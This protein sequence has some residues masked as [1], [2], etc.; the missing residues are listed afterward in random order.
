[1]KT[2]KVLV[3][4]KGSQNGYSEAVSFIRGGISQISDYLAEVAL[5]EGFIAEISEAGKET[6]EIAK[7][8]PENKREKKIRKPK[9]F[10]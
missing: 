2:Y 5:K 3:D 9:E 4:F 6:P 1:M 8:I 7:E 10:K